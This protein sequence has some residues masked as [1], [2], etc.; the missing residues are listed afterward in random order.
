L[1]EFYLQLVPPIFIIIVCSKIYYVYQIAK[2]GQRD[3]SMFGYLLINTIFW[4][5]PI[6]R[7]AQDDQEKKLIRKANITTLVFWILFFVV[8]FCSLI[9]V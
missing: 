5:F 9:F 2:R 1:K 3:S 8:V 4:P 6:L 7:R